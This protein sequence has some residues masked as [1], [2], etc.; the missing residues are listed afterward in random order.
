MQK[1]ISIVLRLPALSSEGISSKTTQLFFYKQLKSKAMAQSLL[2]K[3]WVVLIQGILLIILSLFIFSNP[4]AVLAGISFWFGI[5]VLSAGLIGIINWI[6]ATKEER[7][8]MSLIWSILTLIFGF[9]LI[10]H[11]V[12]TMA[13]ISMIFGW[14]VLA[15]GILLI[16][17]G[18]SVKSANSA[19]WVM[20]VVGILAVLASVFMIFN[21]GAGAIAISTLLGWSVLLTG[22]ALIVLSFVLKSLKPSV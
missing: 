12:A 15:C 7:E 14:W 4:A 6:A 22:I 16:S 20:V 17:N 19:G 13:T 2:K 9:I 8:S 21:I 1:Q 5:L 3:W 10:T 11:L 18:W